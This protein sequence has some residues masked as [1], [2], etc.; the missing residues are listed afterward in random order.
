MSRILENVELGPLTSFGVGGLAERYLRLSS[1]TELRDWLASGQKPRWLLGSGTNVLISDEGLPGL[2]LHLQGGKIACRGRLIVADAGVEWDAVVRFAIERHL[3]GIELMSGIPGTAGGA[4]AINI[5]AYGQA[6]VDRLDWVEVYDPR[7]GQLRRLDIKADDWGY[8]HSPLAGGQLLAIR[9]GLR[10]ENKP[11]GDLRYAKALEYARQHKLNPGSLQERRQIIL[12]ARSAAG[13]LLDDSAG[14]G[15]KTCGSFFG[16][17]IVR[18]EQVNRLL[19]YEEAN[20]KRAQ[21]LEMNRLHGGQAERVSGA[22]VLLAAGF[23]RG[24]AFG[25]VRLHPDN[26]LKL[27]NWRGASAQEIYQ[28]ARSIQKTVAVKLDIG[29]EF[30]VRL[31]GRFQEN[32]SAAEKGYN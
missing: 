13:S 18:P 16:N 19:A 30:E 5:N 23:R 12:G 11:T 2:T 7:N 24:Q 14:G 10:L 1:A 22:H 31:L 27:E 3:W 4:A 6:L 8:K 20:L 29:L 17:P 9:L 32:A 25:K 28:T 21:L 26:V 15:A